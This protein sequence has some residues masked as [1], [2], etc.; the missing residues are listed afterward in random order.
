M[1]GRNDTQMLAN[2]DISM[3]ERVAEQDTLFGD[4]IQSKLRQANP[5]LMQGFGQSKGPVVGR[6]NL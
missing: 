5:G 3:V 6:S 1:I 2:I 4:E